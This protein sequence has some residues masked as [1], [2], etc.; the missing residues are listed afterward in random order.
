MSMSCEEYDLRRYIAIILAGM[1]G[2]GKSLFSTVAKECCGIPVYVMGDIIREEVVKRGLEP[3]QE[4]N[5]RI[6]AELRERYGSNVIA[7]LTI[8]KIA[9]ENPSKDHIIIDG[10]RS[11]DEVECFRKVF[12]KTI[13]V[14]IHSSPMRRFMR[15]VSRGRSDDPRDWDD[16]VSRDMIE[17]S[18]GLGSVIALADHM[19]INE[20]LGREAFINNVASFIEK[21][22]GVTCLKSCLD[23]I[24]H[25]KDL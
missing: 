20:D 24:F 9:S 21:I 5:A 13:I 17:L 18:R 15:L 2:S 11:L 22:F 23:Q 16:F 14:A 25:R 19:I 8:R 10:T 6:A 12:R 3:T 4:N 1:P 7:I